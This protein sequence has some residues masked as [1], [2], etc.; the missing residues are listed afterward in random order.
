M[1]QKIAII[2]AG[3]GGL[4]VGYQSGRIAAGLIMGSLPS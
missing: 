4:S 1:A 3:P 2:D